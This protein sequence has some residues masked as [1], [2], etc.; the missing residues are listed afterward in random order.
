MKKAE[1]HPTSV[2]ARLARSLR[3][4]SRVRGW[5]R[6]ANAIAPPQDAPFVVKNRFGLF[7]G[8]L[9]SYIDRHMYVHGGY[10]DPDL[11]AFF[12][13]VPQERRETILD[14]GA[15][16][17]THSLA[18]ARH[19]NR[20][21]AFEPNPAVWPNFERN[22]ALNGLANVTL[23][24]VGL[25]GRDGELPFFSISKD[26]YG[27]GTVS[28]VEQYDK[29]LKQIGVVSVRSGEDYLREHA[30]NCIDAMKIDVQRYEPEVLRGLA[31]IIRRDRPYIWIAIDSADGAEAVR[32]VF[33]CPIQLLR[34]R[35][36]GRLIHR[37]SLVDVDPHALTVGDYL[38]LPT[39]RQ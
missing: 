6:V 2:S 11:D 26:N 30:I 29:P 1:T 8:N 12:G 20:V 19:F 37:T 35:R 4:L 24:K 17:G 36:G 21:H 34:F 38:V 28:T 31:P 13:T 32:G 39:L 22:V 33:D 9:S 27:L 10:E 3:G 18:F 5:A 25:G 7:A 16:V 14:I 23:H 15:N